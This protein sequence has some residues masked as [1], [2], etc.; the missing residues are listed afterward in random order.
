MFRSTRRSLRWA[1]RKSLK[2][3]RRSLAVGAAIT[4]VM[5][6]VLVIVPGTA[7]AANGTG[8]ADLLNQIA[9]GQGL[10]AATSAQLASLSNLEQQAIANT[11][12]DHG[13]PSTDAAAAATWGRPEAESELW[14][15]LVQAIQTPAASRTAD[16][17]N[18]V[19][20][21]TAAVKRQNIQAADD[22]GLE[23][24]KWAGIGA[25]SYQ[26][27]LASNPSETALQS[28]LSAT[29]LPYTNGGS[30]ST[31]AA[32]VDGGY[33]VY[34][35]PAPYQSE[36]TANVYTPITQ[37]T[38]P[39]TCFTLCTSL[40]GC[41]PPTPSYD[42]FVKWGT[43]DAE[44]T[45]DSPT[46][47]AVG[48][49][50]AEAL[51]LGG[52]AVASAV[53]G[54]VISSSLSG[55]L[56]G[57]SLAAA[58]SPYGGIFTE[59]AAALGTQAVAE[60]SSAVA[61]ADVAGVVGIVIAAIAIAVIEG[62][63]VF[64]AA[65]LPAQLAQ[66]ITSAPSGTPDV[67]AMLASSS[68]ASGLFALFI[69][70]TQ[71]EPLPTT[72]DNSFLITPVP[73][74]SDPYPNAAPCLNAPAIPGPSS[75]DLTFSVQEKGSATSTQ[76]SSITWEDKAQNTTNSG[77]AFGHWF[78][79]TEKANS[80]GSSITFQALH[81][82]YTDWNG[83]EQLAWLAGDPTQGYSFITAQDNPSTPVDP[84][85]CLSDGTCA[86]GPAIDYI[87]TDGND[88]SATLPAGTGIPPLPQPSSGAILSSSTTVSANPASPVVG[89]QVT[90]T[91]TINTGSFAAP[92]TV[93][94][95]SDLARHDTTLCAS[96]QVTSVTQ[97][98]SGLLL[99]EL[100]TATCTATF[101]ST[102]APVIYATYDP[103]P[104]S[105]VLPSQGSLSVNV[106]NQA[107]TSTTVSAS[108]ASPV[109]G[110]PVTLTATVTAEA[111][112]VPTGP[113]SFSD[114]SGTLCPGVSLSSS[115]PYTAACT[116]TYD[117][118]GQRTV[119]ASYAG[120][121]GTTAS[122]GTV[123]VLVRASTTTTVSASPPSPVV[124]A[125]VTF[126]A[127]VADGSGPVPSGPV[128]FS[129]GSGTL[130]PGVSLSSSAPY[131]ATCTFTYDSPGQRTVTASYAGDAGT[132][133]SSGTAQVTVDR[134]STGTTL[135]G[136]PAAPLFGQQVTFSAAVSA[137]APST[138]GPALTGTVTFTV[139]GRQVGNPIPVSGGA[140]SAQVAGL[141]P[142]PHTVVAAY[143]GD[144]NYKASSVTL[145]LT[146]ACSTTIRGT[147]RGSL[148][149]TGS[150]CVEG[151]ALQGAV[152]VRP[153]GALA[154]IGATLHGSLTSTG[155]TGVLICS[156][157]VA[158]SVSIT[159]TTGPVTLGG[160]AGSPCGPDTFHGPV[161]VS[162]GSGQV[163]AVDNMITGPLTVTGNS[164]P[165]QISGSQINGPLSC[166]GNVI[167]PV[168]AGMPNTVS[169]TASGQCS[170]LA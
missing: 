91:A 162:A 154:L 90:F 13:L 164:G 48:N 149:V 136:T 137:L 28:Y 49:D 15:L 93:S 33:C 5:A 157:T 39:Q 36:Y 140:A 43:A 124:G 63:N 156:S 57:T 161:L 170:R 47:A 128:S 160:P 119:T 94:F 12:A 19:D 3:A 52:A 45:L 142:G 110:Q 85:T 144:G 2:V 155:A 46:Y 139:D 151:G 159:G 38:A 78:V 143:S 14:A 88:Y 114:G 37:S 96:A 163:A 55:A 116:F 22:A 122:S 165:V 123:G 41:A 108:P 169:G 40:L 34:Q 112:V 153:G 150:T 64:S 53:S 16:Q 70:A 146:V 167:A 18:A 20:W 125:P 10:Y 121:A 67:A 111:G 1:I 135:S 104:D 68:Q 141:A 54:V 126:T 95:V 89:H 100:N 56:V 11:M 4:T 120:D 118:P 83:K 27:E 60:A 6:A 129:D 131:T 75:S 148:T 127:T 87:G 84:S 42:Q 132:A 97:P 113:V 59:G 32:S 152:T 145:N 105:G 102:Q 29:P 26:A 86:S 31:P 30:A 17:Q 35:S 74:P 98:G 92:G 23:Y 117:S 73:T 65:A 101:T 81:I 51:A 44:S 25:T 77:R 72:C 82:H 21:L 134:A 62:I 106:T 71:P 8:P 61:A 115:A 76:A 168:D 80:D 79:Q 103:T 7:F 99:S 158:G 130:C 66:L 166:T 58:L 138:S 147:Q 50:V 9:L 69:G 133:P 24:A 109:A 107:L